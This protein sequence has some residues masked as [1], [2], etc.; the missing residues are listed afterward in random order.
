[1]QGLTNNTTKVCDL[2]REHEDTVGRLQREPGYLGARLRARAAQ[3][4]ERIL[5]FVDQFEELYTLVPSQE[6]R[7]AFLACLAGVADDT[8]APLRVLLSL[9]SDFLD[10]VGEDK[11]FADEVAR[12][13]VLLQPLGREAL[14][15]ALTAPVEQCGYSFESQQMVDDMVASLAS[16]PGALP[17]LQ[18][19]GSKLWAAR[20]TLRKLL[21]EASY[22]EMGGVSG[23]LAQHADQV[24]H[25]LTPP[26]RQLTPGLFQRLITAEGT[27]A[28]VELAEL[29]ATG[30]SA[31]ELIALVDH[32]IQARLLVVQGR[33]SEDTATVE[34][35]HE[36]LITG[37]PLLRRW[38]EAGRD[39]SAFREQL[40]TVARL[41]QAR[42]RPQGLLWQGDAME[43]AQRWRSRHREI[44]PPNEQQY[45]DAVASLATRATRRRRAAVAGTI[46]ALSLVIAG[47]AVALLQVR[48]AERLAVA[49]ANVARREATRARNAETEVKA[50]LEV[51][52]R[53]QEAKARAQAEVKRSRE[54]LRSVNADLETALGRTEAESRRARAAA[55]TA[56]QAAASSRALASSL[57]VSNGRL[58]ELVQE[59]H[60]RAERLERERGKLA[61]ELR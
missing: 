24:I 42:G 45:L 14:R 25:A 10:R 1:M 17:L 55:E 46:V 5:V 27:R 39:D 51:V 3:T 6:E 41:W 9:R 11:R 61:T 35:I 19:A 16:T 2:L 58:E 21:P 33:R 34:L 22:R 13:L 38:V 53:E 60:A 7:T 30:S 37:W 49:Q 52:R 12:G 15:E 56:R 31:K 47:G 48:H 36:S 23:V 20:D 18:F 43:D 8:A 44:L 26:M 54:D 57:G 32:L 4:G 50:Q 59:E 40:R 28:V 29:A